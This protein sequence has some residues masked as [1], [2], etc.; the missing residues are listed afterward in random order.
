MERNYTVY[1]HTN[2]NNGKVYIGITGTTVEQRWQSG[3]G[4][5]RSPH[6]NSAIKKY[7]WSS[8]D[9]E[10]VRSEL[11]KEEA[12]L[13]ERKLIKRYDSRN[14]QKGYNLSS[15][16]QSGAA[17]LKQSKETCEKKRIACT[18]AWNNPV[19]RREQSDRLKGIVRSEE[20]RQ[21]IS[22]AKK[23]FTVIS[24]EQREQISNTLKEYFSNPE[25]R[26]KASDAA[27]KYPVICLETG[28]VYS[29][30]HDAFRDTGI[31]QANINACCRGKRKR[32]GGYHWGFYKQHANTEVTT[33]TKE[34]VAP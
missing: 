31:T 3:R 4:Y 25:A 19:L 15:G 9:H 22:K 16:G 23:G 10:V 5:S 34:S 33:E 26:K 11:T 21:K 24:E 2:R 7:G 8:F 27:V 18:C 28:R 6:F 30:S 14:P 1:K 29:S 20:T 13:V 32:A 12:C 17:G